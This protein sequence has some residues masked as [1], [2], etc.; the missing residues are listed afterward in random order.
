MADYP[1]ILSFNPTTVYVGDTVSVFAPRHGAFRF[2]NGQTYLTFHWWPGQTTVL[3]GAIRFVDDYHVQFD[4]PSLLRPGTYP[5]TARSLADTATS[6]QSFTVVPGARSAPATA[7]PFT[8]NITVVVP[9]HLWRFLPIGQLP[10]VTFVPG[11]R[12]L[13]TPIKRLL[14]HV[15]NALGVQI[16]PAPIVWLAPGAP[17]GGGGG[18]GDPGLGMAGNR[19]KFL[20]DG[21]EFFAEVYSELQRVKNAKSDRYVH[22]LF[23]AAS[24]RTSLTDPTGG[25]PRIILESQL[26]DIA[27]AGHPVKVIL[28]DPGGLAAGYEPWAEDTRNANE[29]FQNHLDG[30]GAGNIRV[31]LERYG[32]PAESQHQKIAIFSAD[33]LARAIVAGANLHNWYWDVPGHPGT[34]PS[35][36]H[37]T[38][39]DTAVRVEGPATDPIEREWNRRWRK[40][41]QTIPPEGPTPTK[42]SGSSTVLAAITDSEGGTRKDI[43]AQLLRAIRTARAYVYIENYAVIDSAMVNALADQLKKVPG[44]KVIINIPFPTAGDVYSYLH[45]L[46]YVELA[47]ASC[48]SVTVFTGGRLQTVVRAANPIWRVN[49]ANDVGDVSTMDDNKWLADSAIEWGTPGGGIGTQVAAFADIARFSG[50]VELY[51][52]VRATG[53]AA[54]DPIYVHSKLALIDDKIAIVGSANFNYRSLHYDAEM[55]LVITDP[56]EASEWRSRIFAEWGITSPATWQSQAAANRATLDGGTAAAGTRYTVSLKLSDFDRSPPAG[57]APGSSPFGAFYGGRGAMAMVDRTWY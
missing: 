25:G 51:S 15:L 56:S 52:P 13:L 16:I 4:S 35:G 23:W 1:G 34:Y 9:R 37:N 47:F 42:P 3:P 31:R 2:T 17:G 53:G 38:I 26:K 57:S 10:N 44:L 36:Y 46:T 49:Q 32:G 8:T 24:R 27:D 6:A 21:K 12:S 30:Y 29:D 14:A 22:L 39:H 19:V 20:Q 5:V 7:G 48:T 43:H 45:Y 40:V 18:G 28:W 11:P 50:G 33:G 55:S 54:F 41:E